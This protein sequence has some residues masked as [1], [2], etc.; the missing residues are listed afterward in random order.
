[1][2]FLNYD[3]EQLYQEVRTKAEAEGAYEAASWKDMVDAVIQD[4]TEFGELDEDELEEI[5]EKL[6]GK[7]ADFEAD[8]Q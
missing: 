8:T 4:H 1:M 7:F 2:E 3:I 5:R 6:I